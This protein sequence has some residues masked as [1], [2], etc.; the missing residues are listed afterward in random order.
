MSYSAC[1]ATTGEDCLFLTVYT[2]LAAELTTGAPIMVF[3]HG[4]EFIAGHGGGELW[5]GRQMSSMT[6]TILVG[7]NYRLGAL[8]WSWNGN[9]INGNYGIRDQ[10][11]SLQWVQRNGAAFGGDI[12]RVTMFGQSAGAISMTI[13][14]SSQLARKQSLWSRVIVESQPF[15]IPLRDKN[16]MPALMK[17]FGRF[18]GIHTYVA[19]TSLMISTSLVV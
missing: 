19:I 7:V 5:G 16:T 17:E 3:F 1:P 15:T 4:G 10:I 6:G 9:D 2:P 13:L 12:T 8:G 11:A 14:M 18:L